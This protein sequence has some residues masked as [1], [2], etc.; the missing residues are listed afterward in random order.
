M[1]ITVTETQVYVGIIPQNPKTPLDIT[2][3]DKIFNKNK[4]RL[5]LNIIEI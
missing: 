3:N 4:E 2:E 5:K 1:T